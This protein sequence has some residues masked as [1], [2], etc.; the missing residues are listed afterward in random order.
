[1][2]TVFILLFLC[3]VTTSIPADDALIAS[4]G[5]LRIYLLASYFF[6]DGRYTDG[7]G[8]TSG[9][10]TSNFITRDEIPD[11]VG[12]NLGVAIELGITDWVSLSLDWIP[13]WT[14]WSDF[15]A[16]DGLTTFPTFLGYE[17]A[18]VNGIRDLTVAGNL[19]LIGKRS[20]VM[21]SD[22][23][24]LIWSPGFILP[25]PGA[26]AAKEF[27]NAWNRGEWHIDNGKHAFGL[28]NRISFDYVF[29]K[30]FYVNLANGINYFF[31]KSDTSIYS[32]TEEKL[33]AYGFEARFEAEGHLEF[34]IEE[35]IRL[36]FALPAIFAMSSPLRLDGE[37]LEGTD[38]YVLLVRPNMGFFFDD[39][40]VPLEI[41]IAY[42]VPIL[43]KNA[44][45]LYSA[46][47]QIVSNIKIF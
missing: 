16:I 6:T 20:P 1:M 32:P 47:L 40:A 30:V 39:L 34:P 44:P 42:A 28:S 46:T 5:T 36:G 8:Y 18:D 27:E 23:M 15:V 22:R 21:V 38:Q 10:A 12:M 7:W 29:S 25:L 14:A 13:G 33:I 41:E 31:E 11:V 2:R 17:T 19:E 43:G 26:D 24:R 4:K 45:K 37:V 35:G 9:N 3:I